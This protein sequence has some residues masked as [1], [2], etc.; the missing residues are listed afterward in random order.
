LI[1][2]AALPS[3]RYLKK[4][5]LFGRKADKTAILQARQDSIRIADSARKARENILALQKAKLDSVQKADAEKAKAG[6][7]RFNIIV[8][9]FQTPAYARNLAETY[10]KQGY[11]ASIYKAEDIG[12]ERVSAESHNNLR[13][14]I[15]RLKA[16]RDSV[17]VDAW[18]YVRK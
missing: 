6:T 17:A 11:R 10:N 2:I 13:N 9:S 14:A 18:I 15:S 3:C 12:F 4:T 5:G 16:F 7:S 8:G 1:F